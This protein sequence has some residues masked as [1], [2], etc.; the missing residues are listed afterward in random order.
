MCVLSYTSEI[1]FIRRAAF[2]HGRYYKLLVK[3]F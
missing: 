2:T 1:M 3:N